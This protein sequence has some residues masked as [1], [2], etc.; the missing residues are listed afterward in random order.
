M[1]QLDALIVGQGFGGMYMLH[2]AR[3]M[4]LTVLAIEAGG[5][6]DGLT[7]CL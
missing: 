7:S 4:G 6:D 5:Q 2:R 1:R 3:G